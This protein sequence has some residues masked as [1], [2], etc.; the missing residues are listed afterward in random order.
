MFNNRFDKI[1]VV[2]PASSSTGGL[3][4]LHQLVFS[5]NQFGVNAKIAYAN[6]GNSYPINP[7][8]QKYVKDYVDFLSIIHEKNVLVVISEHQIEL[9]DKIKNADVAIWWLSVDN[10]KKVYDPQV[11]YETLGWKGLAW[12]L[13]HKRWKYRISSIKKK[14]K[15]N[16]AQS[17]YAVDFLQ[18]NGFSNV[19]YLSDYINTEY[20][21]IVLD[22]SRK[23]KD[24]VL[25]NPKKGM[26]F[27]KQ[28]MKLDQSIKWIPL[29]NLSNKDVKELL[30]S[31]KVY[32]DFGNHP[33]KDRF[34]REAAICG[35]CVITGKKGAAN[36]FR[37]VSIPERYKFEDRIENGRDIIDCIKMCFENYEFCFND[38][39]KYRKIISLE[40]EQFDLDIKRI[41]FD[42]EAKYEGAIDS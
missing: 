16:L 15:Y 19:E 22:K 11:A 14:I 30:L 38:F 33:G 34:P 3:E 18:K 13:K 4:L 25:Y 2:C 26:A 32:V 29:C 27:S 23:R 8:Y 5:L 9:M 21:Q 37:D 35:C 10:Y 40:K 6:I 41:F 42:K 28:L 12:Y 17:Y 36:F 31:S 20:L 39:E 24:V 7:N 1:Y